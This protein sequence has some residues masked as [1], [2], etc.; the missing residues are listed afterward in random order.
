M[1]NQILS[2]MHKANEEVAEKEFVKA[3]DKLLE[4]YLKPIQKAICENYHEQFGK[5]PAHL[6]DRFYCEYRLYSPVKEAL[7]SYKETG[8]LQKEFVAFKLEPT[9]EILVRQEGNTKEL[10]ELL[11]REEGYWTAVQ[12]KGNT[13]QFAQVLKKGSPSLKD[14]PMQ[15]KLRQE[16]SSESIKA[17]AEELLEEIELKNYSNPS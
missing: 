12:I 13:A 3:K 4:E 7:E 15:K 2:K 5:K 1:L 6:N 9:N 14:H 17:L 16:L 11:G 8:A 10:E